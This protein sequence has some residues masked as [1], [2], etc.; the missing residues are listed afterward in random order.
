[1]IAVGCIADHG[2]YRHWHPHAQGMACPS[3]VGFRA[4]ED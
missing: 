4:K 1:V 2:R 3:G